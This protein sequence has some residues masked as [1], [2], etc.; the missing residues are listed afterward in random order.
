[1]KRSCICED[2]CVE[3]H[4][5]V[6]CD[7]YRDLLQERVDQYGACARCGIHDVDR[8][9]EV[10][11]LVV[12]DVNQEAFLLDLPELFSQSPRIGAVHRDGRIKG[13]QPLGLVVNAVGPGEK[14]E[15]FRNAALEQH[16]H[17]LSH[18]P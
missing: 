13:T 17:L 12:I 8:T 3:V 9:E 5:Y 11:G 7:L 16:F 1:M 10:V 14:S 18:A 15:S 2:R 6:G 4:G